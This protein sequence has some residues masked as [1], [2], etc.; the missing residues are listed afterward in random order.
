MKSATRFTAGFV[1]LAVLVA[2]LF[3][4]K[5]RAPRAAAAGTSVAALSGDGPQGSAPAKPAPRSEKPAAPASPAPAQESTPATALQPL[6]PEC[7]EARAKRMAEDRARY[8]DLAKRIDAFG[9]TDD[10]AAELRKRLATVKNRFVPVRDGVFTDVSCDNWLSWNLPREGETV[11]F[12]LQLKDKKNPFAAFVDTNRQLREH[13]IDF[14]IVTFPTRAQLY[15]ELFLDLP[16][17]DGFAGF[18]PTMPKFALALID[19]GVEVLYLAP[20]FLAARYG[21][22]GDKSDQLFLKYNQHWTP[23]A[24]EMTASLVRDRLGKMPWFQQGPKKEGTDFVVRE[25][26]YQ[27]K[28]VW[29]G[30]PAG[31]NEDRRL[32]NQITRPDLREASAILPS[33]RI[34]LFTGSFGDF[35]RVG[36]CDFTTQLFRFTGQTIDLENPKGGLEDA[37]RDAFAALSPAIKSKKKIVIWMLPEAAFRESPAWR[38][39]DLFPGEPEKP[40][41]QPK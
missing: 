12:A 2:L 22:D 15:P 16:S 34:T 8:E 23:R 33:S 41:K 27:T 1:A 37:C 10:V 6:S 14:L 17:L 24:A 20:E 3:A 30:A 19:A 18:S 38:L 31:A 36:N 28:I 26:W 21:K 5:L 35:H 29:G 4:A 39:I 32:V 25:D 7:E 9:H 13:G 11:P 40:P